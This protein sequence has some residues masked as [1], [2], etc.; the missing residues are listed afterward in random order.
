MV[1]VVVVI[2]K[3]HI[4]MD[5]PGGLKFLLENKIRKITVVTCEIQVLIFAFS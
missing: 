5:R 1:M 2:I 3:G 4:I